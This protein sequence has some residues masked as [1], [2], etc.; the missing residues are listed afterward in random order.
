MAIGAATLWMNDPRAPSTAQ[1][2]GWVDAEARLYEVGIRW[3]PGKSGADYQMIVRYLVTVNGRDYEGSR[4]AAGDSSSSPAEV[5]AL[6]VP[7]A[8]EASEF[9]LQDLG[10]LNPRRTWSVAYLPVRARYDARDAARSEL[11]L[12]RPGV[13]RTVAYWTICGIA[14]LFLLL[15]AA[16]AAWPIWRTRAQSYANIR[17]KLSAMRRW[18]L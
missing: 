15:G 1:R 2:S 7:F 11:L 4:I 12:G 6:I 5:K 8:P 18:R 3:R 16:L 17:L 9:T 10:P 14:W 13:T